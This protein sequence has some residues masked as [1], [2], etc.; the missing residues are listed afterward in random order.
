MQC[1]HCDNPPCVSVCPTGASYKRP[2]GIVAINAQK[3]IGC[4][5]CILS[6]PYNVRVISEAG[7][8]VHKCS[9]C[10]TLIEKNQLPACTST[11]PTSVRVFGDLNDPN[12]EITKLIAT[13]KTILIGKDLNTKPSIYYIIG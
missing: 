9:F 1:Q 4:K 2:D 6:C 10:A 13:K 7:G 8:F 3:C 5:Y 11:C 12:S